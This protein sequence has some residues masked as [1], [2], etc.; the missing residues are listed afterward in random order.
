[1]I[2]EVT[3]NSEISWA[4]MCIEVYQE[5]SIEMYLKERKAGKLPY[6]FV[7]CADDDY[8]GMLSLSIRNDYVQGTSTSPVAYVEGIYVKPA[9]RNKGIAKQLVEFSKCWALERGCS[10]L[11]SDCV[12]DNLDSYEFHKSVGFEEAGRVICFK[13]AV[14]EAR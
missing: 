1:M 4:E 7:Y 8:V 12:I 6:E 13:M 9:Y 5:G 11:A 14:D 3:T 10:E 2:Q